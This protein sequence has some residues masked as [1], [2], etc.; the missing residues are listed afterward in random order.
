VDRGWKDG[1][2]PFASKADLSSLRL[3][4]QVG[5]PAS[6]WWIRRTAW[7]LCKHM[8]QYTHSVKIRSI[9][10]EKGYCLGGKYR[11]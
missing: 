5:S 2:R 7:R 6:T 4:K 10:Y 11:G 8:I 3:R 1:A 9:A